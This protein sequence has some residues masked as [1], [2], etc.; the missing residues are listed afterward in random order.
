MKSKIAFMVCTVL[1]FLSVPVFALDVTTDVLLGGFYNYSNVFTGKSKYQTVNGYDNITVDGDY[2][3]IFRAGGDSLGFDAFF[4]PCPFGVYLRSGL[5]GVSGVER[6]AGDVTDKIDNTEI[7]YNIFCDVG[8]VYAFNFGNFSLNLAPAVSI[9]F[10]NAENQESIFKRV[11]LDSLFGVGMT[12]DI[13]A[14]Y[15]YKYFVCSAGCAASFYPLTLVSSSDTK[16]KYSTNIRDT[17]A[18]N[19]RPYISVGVSIRERTS[20]TISAGGVAYEK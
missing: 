6:T 16:I 11:T 8:G 10:V 12:A 15:R 3:A 2:N 14:K 7:G 19:L 5:M 13:Y 18:Y 4:N 17:M 20:S 9:L 1:C